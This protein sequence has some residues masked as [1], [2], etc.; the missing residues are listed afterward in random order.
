VSE[1]LHARLAAR[2]SERKD[3]RKKGKR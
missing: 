1:V 3:E 2:V